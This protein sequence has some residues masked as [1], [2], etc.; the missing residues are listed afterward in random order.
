MKGLKFVY[1]VATGQ[2][3]KAMREVLTPIANAATEAMR[4]V[5]EQVKKEGRADI[6]SAGFSKKWQNAFRVDVYPKKGVSAGAAAHAYHKIP[7]A[8]VFETGATIR[9]KPLMWVP[10][11]W[12]PKRSGGKRMDAA[13]YSRMLGPLVSINRPGRPPMLAAPMKGRAG[14][15][16]TMSKLQKGKG[17]GEGTVLTPILIGLSAVNLR[18]RFHLYRIIERG[19]ASLAAAYVA[20]V[21]V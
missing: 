8:E 3:D 12:A 5:G 18:K 1:H 7:Y 14:S 20:N 15:A 13:A 21:K 2:F 17:G 11:S 19:R 6:A 16:V 4:D 10:T 9:G